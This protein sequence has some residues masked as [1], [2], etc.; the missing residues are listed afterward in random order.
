MN[1][2]RWQ[3]I[4]ELFRTVVNRPTGERD[5]YLTRVCDG[6]EELQREVLSLLARDTAEDFIRSPIASVAQ[7]FTAKPNDDLTGERIGPYRVRRLIGRGGM[8]TVYEAERDDEQF[9]QRVAIKIIKPGMD[10]DFVRDR[11]LRERQILASL[12]HP[13]IARLIDGGT[14]QDGLP[15]FVMEFVAGDPITVYCRLHQLS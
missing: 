6:D 12:D 13:Y 7:S 4:E 1:L 11:F 2:E 5:L 3:R 14:T 8:G 15:Y 10:T 9:R